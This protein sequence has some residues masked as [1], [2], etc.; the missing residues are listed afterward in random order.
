LTKHGPI[1][2]IALDL[3]GTLFNKD[4]TISPRNRSALRRAS[5]AGVVI[6]LASGRM[7]DCISPAADALGID[8]P[9]I[10]YN[11]GM[12]RGLAA[13]G[14]PVLFHR[15]L[16]ARYCD[17]LIDFCRGRYL[18]NV[19]YDDTLYAEEMPEL[20]RFSEIYA[21]R[22]GAVY[23][24]VPDLGPF[25]GRDATKAVI[26][27]DPPERER[28][29]EEWSPRWGDETTIVKTDPE[30]LE[31][32][33]RGTDKGVAL[34]GLCD[35]LGVPPEAAMA[36]GD[37]DNDAEMLVRRGARRRHGELDPKDPRRGGRGLPTHQHR[38]RRSRR[39]RATRVDLI[40]HLKDPAR[41]RM[42]CLVPTTEAPGKDPSADKRA[43]RGR[44]AG[45]PPATGGDAGHGNAA[46][47][48]RRV[49]GCSSQKPDD[50][51]RRLTSPGRPSARSSS[52]CP[53]DPAWPRAPRPK[54]PPVSTRPRLARPSPCW[55]TG[56][57]S[58]A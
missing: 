56:F 34:A 6:A 57:G 13:D 28:L 47:Y 17:E 15:P 21:T 20:R 45:A 4:K 1:R 8:C 22:T 27:A 53:W 50:V 43:T 33:E 19:Y 49:E 5:D 7:T 14:R 32:M 24:Y 30:Y 9:I 58:R 46:A 42:P 12:V 11:G 44:M 37:G 38:G 16:T 26:I 54:G 39:R 40:R 55:T 29:Y 3:D 31:F 36:C 10:A 35:S 52:A 2:L 23:E 18:L 41:A 51:D 48:A 25:A